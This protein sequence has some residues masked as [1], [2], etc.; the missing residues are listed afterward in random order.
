MSS[1]QIT[2]TPDK[3]TPY[4]PGAPITISW[5]VVDADN[6][7]ETL[8]LTGRDSQGNEVIT[9]VVITRQDSFTM[10]DVSW[11][12]TGVKL[13]IDNATRKATGVVPTA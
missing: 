9:D 6:S 3:S 11:V 10:T 12:R 8:R 4:A 13:A 2:A 5:T 7:T 1:P